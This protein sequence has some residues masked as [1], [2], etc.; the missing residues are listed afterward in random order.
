MQGFHGFQ[1][2]HGNFY[3]YN[4]PIWVLMTE[5]NDTHHEHN[6]EHIERKHRVEHVITEHNARDKRV[7]SE[8]MSST[9]HLSQGSDPRGLRVGCNVR[10]EAGGGEYRLLVFKRVL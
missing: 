10:R 7:Y 8:H 5:R 4:G 9:T 1:S 2:T 6:D 3:P